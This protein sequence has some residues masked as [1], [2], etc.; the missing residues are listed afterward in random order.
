MYAIE[1]RLQSYLYENELILNL[2]K[3]KTESMLFGTSKR[4]S[5]EKSL[6]LTIDEHPINNTTQ[7]CY[8]GNKLDPGLSLNENFESSYKKASGRLHL[9]RKL[10]TY[11]NND[12]AQKVF[13]MMIVP[14]LTY[15]KL[16]IDQDTTTKAQLDR[17][18]SK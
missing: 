18:T 12:A 1:R 9:L 5:K 15:S 14:I 10:R 7:Y 11:L 13:E 8:L 3:G 17:E 4:R 16:T 2:K 6:E